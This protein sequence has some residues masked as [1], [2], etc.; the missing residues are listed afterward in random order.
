MG[1]V[2]ELAGVC[3]QDVERGAH[4]GGKMPV[5][6]SVADVVSPRTVPFH[7]TPKYHTRWHRTGYRGDAAALIAVRGKTALTKMPVESPASGTSG[8]PSPDGA[9]DGPFDSK[10]HGEDGSIGN[11]GA[12]QRSPLPRGG[13]YVPRPLEE[14]L[15]DMN[16]PA[17]R[18][19]GK[20]IGT[21]KQYAAEVVRFETF[22]QHACAQ[23]LRKMVGEESASDFITKKAN[24]FPPAGRTA[25]PAVVNMRKL[26]ASPPRGCDEL[27][28][29]FMADRSDGWSCSE[30]KMKKI[31]ATLSGKFHDE[32]S[33]GP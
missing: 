8:A 7:K 1:P 33:K 28:H 27:V 11:G 5:S 24:I 10:S 6:T 9:R 16:I 31:V 32:G 22:V 15:L 20:A 30:G 21:L 2:T 13:T 14:V 25:G 3:L 23:N 12:I 29:A 17:M 26:Y 18:D 19:A 4:E